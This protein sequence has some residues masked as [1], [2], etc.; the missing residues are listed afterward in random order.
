MATLDQLFTPD[1]DLRDT[2]IHE[3]VEHVRTSPVRTGV[4]LAAGDDRSVVTWSHDQ[5]GVEPFSFL[6]GPAGT[7]KTFLARELT[8]LRPDA[9]LCAT[10]GIAAVNL[11]DAVTINSLLGYY[12]TASMMSAYASGW[13][14][15]RLRQLRKAGMRLLILDEVS[16]LD[17]NALTTL[18]SALD[19]VNLTKTYDAELEQ[20]EM[21]GDDD[22]ML[23]L[24]LVGDFAQLPPVEA[25]F[26]FTAAVW[27]RFA[28]H[29]TKL[30]HIWRQENKAF[31]EALQSIRKGQAGPAL[32]VLESRFAPVLDFHFP[33]TTIVAQNAEVDRINSLRLAQ[34]AGEGVSWPTLRSGEQQKD[35]LRLI[36]EAFTAKVG[37]LVMILA[38][39]SYGWDEDQNALGY[40]YVNGDLA[41]VLSKEET[42]IRVKL[43]RSSEE[44]LV[45]PLTSEWKEPTGKKTPAYTVKG[46]VTRMPLRLAWATTVHK[47]QGLTLD[48]VQVGIGNWMFSKPS[49]LYVALSRCRTLEGLRIVGNAKQ[50]AGRCKVDPQIG[51]FL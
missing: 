2:P 15:T 24:L 41:T 44:V 33:G 45:T 10:T 20:V 5:L 8:R 17:A 1:G 27:E 43:H 51:A 7:G 26:A 9:T 12:D 39:K 28:A 32:P 4:D 18:V 46:A 40:A 47:S 6:S 48:Q 31:V 23:K 42:G 49:M 36:P 22:R 21:V 34:T 11:G 29:T 16:M 3:N 25:P 19:D 50:L 14:S 35:W 37:A 38:N 30:T 13:L